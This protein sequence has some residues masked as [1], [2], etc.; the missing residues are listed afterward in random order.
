MFIS[1]CLLYCTLAQCQ[2][3]VSAATGITQMRYRFGT[4]VLERPS[5]FS[6]DIDLFY[7]RGRGGFGVNT[8]FYTH[9][10]TKLGSPTQIQLDYNSDL[11]R[12]V[13]TAPFFQESTCIKFTVFSP[14]IQ[15]SIIDSEKINI[16]LI[17][18]VSYIYGSSFRVRLTAIGDG[19]PTVVGYQKHQ[20]SE[21]E[22][23]GM[24]AVNIGYNLSSNSMIGIKL[25]YQNTLDFWTGQVFIQAVLF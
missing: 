12:V 19:S 8:S 13:Y 4:E 21:V 16:S 5:S 2:L 9:H 15:F 7:K 10:S 20:R 22:Q 6:Y 3:S 23:F 11:N 1:I 25:K 24:G 14:Y 17:G 18:G